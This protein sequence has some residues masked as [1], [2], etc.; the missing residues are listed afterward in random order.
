[1]LNV[2]LS[3]QIAGLLL[4]A[5][6]II[7]LGC[8]FWIVWSLLFGK[9]AVSHEEPEKDTASKIIDATPNIICAAVDFTSPSEEVEHELTKCVDDAREILHHVD[10]VLE[11][12]SQYET[13]ELMHADG[14]ISSFKQQELSQSFRHLFCVGDSLA[15]I[16]IFPSS[17]LTVYNI[18]GK[19]IL[20]GL[21]D[22]R[23]R[24]GNMLTSESIVEFGGYVVDLTLHKLTLPNGFVI[25]KGDVISL[26][27][28]SESKHHYFNKFVEADKTAAVEYVSDLESKSLLKGRIFGGFKITSEGNLDVI[29]YRHPEQSSEALLGGNTHDLGKLRGYV[30][31]V[32]SLEKVKSLISIKPEDKRSAA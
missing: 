7:V 15:G 14:K 24:R 29:C 3:S 9:Y 26:E 16:G 21:E 19:T 11:A 4:S 1:M 8:F 12:M 28:A 25:E 2:I 18:D 5:F 23:K 20:S 32:N 10:D 13:W 17:V 31:D 6:V 30:V 22:W 27:M